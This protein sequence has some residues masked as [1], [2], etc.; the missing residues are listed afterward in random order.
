MIEIGRAQ[1]GKAEYGVATEPM[2]HFAGATLSLLT[3]KPVVL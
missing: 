1:Q 2:S 3:L